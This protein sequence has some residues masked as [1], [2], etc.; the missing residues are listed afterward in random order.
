MCLTGDDRDPEAWVVGA[1]GVVAT[2]TALG[3]QLGQSVVVP[4]GVLRWQRTGGE[5]A[6]ALQDAADGSVLWRA[7]A[8]PD[9]VP[10][11]G[12]CRPQVAGTAAATVEHGLLV[13]RGCRLSAVFTPDGD[14]LDDP[15][16]AVTVQV[17]PSGDGT[18]LRTTTASSSGA[19]ETTQLVRT[20]GSVDRIVPGRPLVPLATD[21]TADPTRLL[22][23]P[24]GVQAL[25]PSGTERWTTSGTVSRVLVVA[26]G[27]AVL[28]LG[29]VV[30][31]VD[32]A[33]GR[34]TWSFERDS[35]GTVDAV[36]GAFTDGDV[37]ALTLSA[38]EDAGS[39]R[40][41]ALDLE[42]GDVLWDEL[43]AGDPGAFRAVGGRLVHLDPAAER[44]VAYG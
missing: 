6:V 36:V 41:V 4:G 19:V 29:Y 22:S 12:M 42:D 15:G 3:A 20:D 40:F 25:D 23:V 39:G 14:R 33:S 1:D 9:D 10:R 38:L 30:R 17:V 28:D 16:P 5:L 35:L 31:G 21:G 44:L 32:L 2:R 7:T 24:S 43:Y 37:A 34:T 13:V 27:T 26:G 8:A 11:E 18:Y